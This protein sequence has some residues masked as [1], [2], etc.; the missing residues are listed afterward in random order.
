MNRNPR[1]I[2][3]L[4]CPAMVIQMAGCRQAVAPSEEETAVRLRVI[5]LSEEPVHEPVRTSGTLV[6]RSELKLSFKTGGII[7]SISV[8]EGQQ[9][10]KGE[11]M[12]SLDLS[13]IEAEARKARAALDK[14][15]RDYTRVGNLYRDTVATLEQFQNART[16]LDVA[17]SNHEI[18]E[19]NLKHSVIRAPADGKVLKKLTEPGEMVAPGM[20][21]FLFASTESEWVVRAAVSDRDIVRM[22][23]GDSVGLHFDAFPGGTF[24][25]RVVEKGTVA[26][27]YTGTYDVEIGM[28]QAPR[29]LVSGLVARA[30]IYPGEPENR[31]C[32][33]ESA[34]TEGDGM[35]GMVTVIR[36]GRPVKCRILL[37]GLT[38]KGLIVKE[39][40]QAGDTLVAEGAGFLLPG[41]RFELE[42]TTE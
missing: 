7:N 39:G 35:E 30:E 5:T 13:E 24:T 26:D 8:K 33:P 40:L 10:N 27:P 25:G 2:R 29:N 34:L 28:E 23:T 37:E 22:E 42:F 9:L 32:I 18:A 21:V 41:S 17:R 19:F 36:N 16:A 3:F 11:K 15:W 14:A 20:P 12:A 31:I 4:L 1:L 38:D 6:A